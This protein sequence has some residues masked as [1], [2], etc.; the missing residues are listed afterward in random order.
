MRPLPDPVTGGTVAALRPF[1]NVASDGDFTLA[2]AWLL[3]ALRDRGPYP[4]LALTGEHGSAKSTFAGVLRA[5]TD[6]STAPLRA[7]SRE[8]R[9]LFIAA[10]N[11]HVLCFDNVSGLPAWTSD[12]L[13][14]LST[15]GGF[16]VRQLYSDAD[17]ILFDAARPIILNGI[18]DI[19]GRPDL[20]DRSLFLHLE[21]IADDRRRPEA[22]LLAAF[23][24]AR[25]YI[26]GAL[27]GA[28]VE[29]LRRLPSTRLAR[30]PRLADFA[31]WATAC[32]TAIWPAGT[33][34]A[35]YE[36]NRADAVD[37]VLEADPVAS[38]VREMMVDLPEFS[39]TASRLLEVLTEKVGQDVARRAKGWPATAKDASR[40][41]KRAMTFLRAV[42]IEVRFRRQGNAR[43]RMID[44]TTAKE[45]GG[46][47]ASAVAAVSAPWPNVNGAKAPDGG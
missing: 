1:L 20:A 7:L 10:S 17:E 19:V 34:W 15:G 44:I 35:A 2:V 24:L 30:L 29:G 33:F 40:C 46:K 42:G 47:S 25:P 4:V 38:A 16:S 13:C 14:R 43:T 12:T 9:D 5:I 11:G 22:D 26:I 36:A 23:E 8:D 32:E 18:T 39:G 37:T 45:S 41:L 6:P 3:A 21:P 28:M 27:L 31:L